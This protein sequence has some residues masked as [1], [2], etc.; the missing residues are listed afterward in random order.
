MAAKGLQ[1][2]GKRSLVPVLQSLSTSKTTVWLSQTASS[3]LSN[4]YHLDPKLKPY[5]EPLVRELRGV[6]YQTTTSIVAQ[7]V[8]SQLVSDGLVKS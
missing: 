2:Y 3:V 8:L 6:S 5:L 1:G 7:K 4:L